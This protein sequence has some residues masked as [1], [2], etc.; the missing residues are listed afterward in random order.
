MGEMG[1]SML[2]KKYLAHMKDH[3][4]KFKMYQRW[5]Q[6]DGTLVKVLDD[7]S[8]IPGTHLNTE[9][10]NIQSLSPDGHMGHAQTMMLAAWRSF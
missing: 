5:D 3:E 1:N 7:L 2:L 4:I 9:G 6:Q 10:K 8:L